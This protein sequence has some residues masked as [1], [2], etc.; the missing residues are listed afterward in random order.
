[1][2]ITGLFRKY[3]LSADE[4]QEQPTI[5]LAGCYST[6]IFLM[7]KACFKALVWLNNKCLP[8]YSGK[9][10]ATLK[11]WQLALVGFRYWALKNAL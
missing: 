1:M 10:P 9:D 8:K 3:A 4:R 5:P 6:S 2:S 11:K 7:K